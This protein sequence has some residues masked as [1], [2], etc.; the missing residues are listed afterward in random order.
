MTG[1]HLPELGSQV[2]LTEAAVWKIPYLTGCLSLG[3]PLLA[4]SLSLAC[5]AVLSLHIC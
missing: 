5:N 1:R 3:V 4:K 2:Q